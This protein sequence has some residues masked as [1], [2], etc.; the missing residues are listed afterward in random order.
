MYILV[1]LAFSYPSLILGSE[2]IPVFST[3]IILLILHPLV[4]LHLIIY[5]WL[6]T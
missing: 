2:L 4:V 1:C 6:S 3:Y 5:E